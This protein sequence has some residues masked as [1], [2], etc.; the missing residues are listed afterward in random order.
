MEVEAEGLYGLWA[1]VEY[2][3]MPGR[4]DDSGWGR[5][6]GGEVG[7]MIRPTAFE[8]DNTKGVPV[9]IWIDPESMIDGVVF[10]VL[11]QNSKEIVVTLECMRGLVEA[12]EQL[13]A[14]RKR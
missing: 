13:M 4:G 3:R 8:V 1:P 14:G 5:E 9:D 6:P 7:A 10:F 12:A 2:L 11:D